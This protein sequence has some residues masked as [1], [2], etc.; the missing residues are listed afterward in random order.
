[1]VVQ[2]V[3]FGTLSALDFN[4]LS[5]AVKINSYRKRNGMRFSIDL[6]QL[7]KTGR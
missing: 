2:N 5:K 7:G 1:M 6:Q 4:W 3:I